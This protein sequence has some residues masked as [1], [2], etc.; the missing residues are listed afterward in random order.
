MRTFTLGKAL[1]VALLLTPLFAHAA[2]LGRLNVQSS[3][4][5]PLSAEIDLVAVRGDEASTLVAR[6]ASPDDYQR[7]N[8]QYNAGMTGLRLSIEKRPNGQ[9]YIKITGSRPVN[10][11]FVDLLIELTSG[12]GGKLVRE[13]TALLDPPGY[14]QQAAQ[15]APAAPA[16]APE[17]RPIV[18]APAAPAPKPVTRPAAASAAGAQEYGPIAKGETLGKIAASL[19]PQGVS[20]EQM[21]V[22]LYRSNPDAFIKK[23]MNL[24]K[25]GKI[26]RIPDAQ[27][28]AAITQGEAMKEYR[29][30]VADWRAYSGRVADAAAQAPEGAAT[31]RG[32]ITAKVDDPAAAE[33]KDVVKLSKGDPGKGGKPLSGAARET[34]AAEDKTA[35]KQELAEAKDRIAQLEKTVK[36]GQKLAELKSPGMAA[37]QQKAEA[38]KADAAKAEPGKPVEAA[39]P[40]EPAKAEAK[41]DA[42]PAAKPDA[43]PADEAKKDVAATDKPA[44]EAKPA[45]K[46]KPKFVAPPPPPPEPSLM[47]MAMENLP[48]IGGG[49]LAVVL[50]GVGIAALRRRRAR[51]QDDDELTPVAPTMGAAAVAAAAADLSDTTATAAAAPASDDV[52]PVAEAEVYIAYGRDGQAEEILKEAMSRDP[53][54][55]DVQVK[56]A[57]VY[58]AR[59]DAAA[60]GAVADSMRGL[61]GGVGDN[62]LKIAALG[63]AL[64]PANPLYEAGRD[65]APAPLADDSPTGTD[66]DFD[67]GGDTAG[68]PDIALDAD[69]AG[70]ATEMGGMQELAAAADAGVAPP[71]EAQPDFNLD[72]GA[73]T[74]IALEASPPE[75]SS[76]DFNFELPPVD[77]P[78]APAPEPA[79]PAADA[80][81]D[82]KIDVGD[83]NINLDDPSTAAAPAEAKDGH[84]YDVQQKFDLAKAYQEMGD[85][86]GAREILQEVL[87]E[88]DNEQKD[89]AQKLLATLG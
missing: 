10:E 48:L 79:A 4:G 27:E 75:A 19:K 43:A 65:A 9:S 62:W 67:L 38:A 11:P 16:A 25:S 14:G 32:R 58:A 8:L 68:T 63:Y 50:G 7:A 74:D 3:L 80:G 24:V 46:P 64:D 70:Q 84:W 76:I 69:P 18:A 35:R 83:L 47:D 45:A 13:Y 15:P 17:S 77:A 53:A 89:Q 56:L 60:F 1:A 61:T 29:A 72:A 59:K 42:A 54:R 55:E 57:E 71:A 49:A 33:G 73:Q 36:D 44:D 41:P 85:N 81:L 52:D 39:K 6:L 30:Q 88:G 87:K 51:S 40:A 31:A 78:A 21:L 20:L 26:L 12:T 66:L 34:A 2:G 82:F 28:L 5:Q 37:A 22:G 86:D 23:N